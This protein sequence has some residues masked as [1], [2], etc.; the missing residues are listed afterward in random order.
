MIGEDLKVVIR[1]D[2][3][4][5]CLYINQTSTEKM[6]SIQINHIQT[7]LIG[8]CILLIIGCAGEIRSTGTAYGTVTD[9]KNSP[10]ENANV[11]LIGMSNY[12]TL[13]DKNG[14]YRFT[15][16]PDS[17]YRIV[18]EKT[19]H[20]SN[21]KAML[22]FMVYGGGEHNLNITLLKDCDYYTPQ[23]AVDY[24][25]RYGYDT[26]LY[27]G[28]ITFTMPYPEGTSISMYPDNTQGFSETSTFYKAGNRMIRWTLNNTDGQYPSVKGNIRAEIKGTKTLQLLERQDMKISAASLSQQKYLGREYD[29][30]KR[31]MIDPTDPEI[32]AL[33]EK[34]KSETGS[35]DVW[36]VANAMY[37]WVKTN[38]AYNTDTQSTY[39]QSA[40]EVLQNH[41]GDCD[42][43]SFLYISLCRAAGIPAR[44]VIGYWINNKPEGRYFGHAWAEFY[45]GQW[46]P[47]ELT[48]LWTSENNAVA[49]QFMMKRD[50]ALFFGVDRADHITTFVDD[51]TSDSMGGYNRIT[52]RSYDTPPSYT[53]STYYEAKEYEPMY[54]AN[55]ADGTRKLVKEIE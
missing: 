24:V 55:C 45:Y 54:I 17:V 19:G 4:R 27:R 26:T 39:V 18:A 2:K 41:R 53:P 34:I 28:E 15:D 52:S 42:E 12:T 44:F 6:N 47:V 35:D 40:I 30:E 25:V 32:K 1:L 3:D 21:E 51:G 33:A 14:N 48:E 22:S 46:A 10:L 11:T 49:D 23:T 9:T 7:I 20:K 5:T 31:A 37:V 43:L 38:I 29:E 36:T 13:T 16:L 50:N 8:A